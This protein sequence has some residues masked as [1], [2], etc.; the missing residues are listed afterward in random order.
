MKHALTIFLLSAACAVGQ[1]VDI[2]D[3]SLHAA[4]PKNALIP[5]GT[6]FK[7][8]VAPTLADMALLGWRKMLP[9]EVPGGFV[10]VGP[11]EYR[12]DAKD[13]LSAA[14]VF[15]LK[16]EKK[17]ADEKAAEEAAAEAARIEAERIAAEQA[18]AAT[19]ERA[20]ERATI[21]EPFKADEKQV[22]A[23]GKLYDLA[24]PKP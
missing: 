4:L 6:G 8:V 17:V 5:D 19:A 24:R 10:I 22:E 23:I 2:D 9:V 3:G 16:T 18:A 13:A 21:V 11:I 14:P 20:A 7:G 12:Q 15:E 1:Y